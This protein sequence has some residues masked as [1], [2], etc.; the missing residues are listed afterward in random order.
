[1]SSCV[2]VCVPQRDVTRCLCDTKNTDLMCGCQPWG[3]HSQLRVE[4]LASELLILPG[5]WDKSDAQ[6]TLLLVY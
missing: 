2:E 4:P 3:L 1:M 5:G 6:I